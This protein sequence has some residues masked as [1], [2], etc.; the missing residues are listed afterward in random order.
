MQHHHLSLAW[1]LQ[2]I[3]KLRCNKVKSQYYHP[4]LTSLAHS[5]KADSAMV[6]Y[7]APHIILNLSLAAHMT[8]SK[9][10]HFVATHLRGSLC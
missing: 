5:Q 1:L 2:R 4:L 9:L 7:L 8:P 3:E 10:A 6:S